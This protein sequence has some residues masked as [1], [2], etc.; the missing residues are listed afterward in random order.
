MEAEEERWSILA[1]TTHPQQDLEF[2]ASNR[3]AAGAVAEGL[4]DAKDA[5]TRRVYA[6]AWHDFC[7]WA[8]ESGRE[9][10]PTDPRKSPYT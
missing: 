8:F 6:S 2:S 3:E 5:S 10:L 9:S 4:R 1:S 7:G